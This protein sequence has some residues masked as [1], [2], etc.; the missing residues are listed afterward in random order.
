[1]ALE[2]GIGEVAVILVAVIQCEYRKRPPGCRSTAQPLFDV[3][4]R[5]DLETAGAHLPDDAVE[6][7]RRYL[8]DAVRL[9]GTRLSGDHLMQHEDHAVTRGERRCETIGP[10]VVER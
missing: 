2:H 9:E 4:E 1:M 6:K 10:G 3:V 7:L 5:N 8:Q